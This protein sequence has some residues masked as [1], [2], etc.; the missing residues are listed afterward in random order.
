[1]NVSPV[2]SVTV[3]VSP[4]GAPW[5]ALTIT[6]IRLPAGGEKL[7]VDRDLAPYPL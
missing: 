4:L 1:M 5:R 7:A 6:S 3:T 2:E